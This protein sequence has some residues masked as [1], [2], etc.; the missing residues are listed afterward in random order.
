[1][2][3]LEFHRYLY[4]GEAVDAAAKRLDAY[5]EL[6]RTQTATHWVIEVRAKSPARERQVAGELRNFAL[7]LTVERGGVDAEGSV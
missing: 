4:A 3:R 2:I 7:G 1:M 6:S 5:A